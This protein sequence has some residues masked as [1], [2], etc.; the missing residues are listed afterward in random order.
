MTAAAT[1]SLAD[2]A[3]LSGV[4][5]PVV[6]MWRKRPKDGLPFP[7]PTHDG[8]FLSD[9]VVDGLEQTQ[10]GNNPNARRD[11]ALQVARPNMTMPHSGNCSCCSRQRQ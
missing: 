8:R 2:I 4:Q 7:E 6:T 3:Q 11:L 5:R 1:L 9:E 10:R